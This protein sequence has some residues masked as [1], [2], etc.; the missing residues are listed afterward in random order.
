MITNPITQ[1]VQHT[2]TTQT[3]INMYKLYQFFY[4]IHFINWLCYYELMSE[5][6][7]DM[8]TSTF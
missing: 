7:V 4:S 5:I 1:R 6:N 3:T 2:I 8:V